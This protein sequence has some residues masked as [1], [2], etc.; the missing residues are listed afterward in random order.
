M[1]VEGIKRDTLDI[2]RWTPIQWALST[3]DANGDETTVPVSCYFPYSGDT[4]PN[5]ITADMVYT[6][7]GYLGKN[8]S[9]LGSPVDVEGKIVLYDTLVPPLTPAL[10]MPFLWYINEPDPAAFAQIPT[11]DYRRSWLSEFLVKVD[12]ASLKDQGAVGIVVIADEPYRMAYGDE[13]AAATTHPYQGIPA[14]FV[15]RDAGAALK[16]QVLL[17]GNSLKVHLTMDAKYEPAN[18][19][20]LY[21]F[22]P[23]KNWGNDND[24][25]IVIE[26]HTDGENAVEENGG[27]AV[28]NIAKYFSH[29]PQKY[30]ER[31]ICIALLTC[32]LYYYHYEGFTCESQ[33]FVEDHP[34]IV[35]K[36]KGVVAVEHLGCK[37]WLETSSGEYKDM[38]RMEIGALFVNSTYPDVIKKS[39]E[40][41]KENDLRRVAVLRGLPGTVEEKNFYDEGYLFEDPIG[42][43]FGFFQI[44]LPGVN[45]IMGPTYLYNLESGGMD[46]LDKTRFHTEVRTFTQLT[47]WLVQNGPGPAAESDIPVLYPPYT[48][49]TSLP[50]Y[51]WTAQIDALLGS[52]PK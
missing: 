22:L 26:S 27:I 43:G 5:G 23:G 31:T 30:R 11:E 12:L 21:G 48:A 10:F 16:Q 33:R 19:Y 9:S 7:T 37:N 51:P 36:I 4:G 2:N 20:Q 1:G 3:I 50:D 34:D 8:A 38:G 13:Y 17:G 35:E 44:G 25:Y 47:G 39:I 15:D 32:H 24:E 28:L 40:L 6:G 52:A 45:Y 49:F 18:T 46:K 41:V 14:V 29:I 42:T